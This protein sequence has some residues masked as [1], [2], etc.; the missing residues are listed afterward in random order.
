M[1]DYQLSKT[2]MRQT[3]GLIAGSFK[4]LTRGHFFLIQRA[5]EECDR[6]IV[7]VSTGD[8]Q[9]S[10]EVP[11][12]WTQMEL[13]W[14]KFLLKAMPSNVS[15]KFVSHPIRGVIDILR[16]ANQ[17]EN[18]FNTYIIYSDPEDMANNYNSRTQVKY[19]PR[20]LKNEQVIFKP[21]ERK[22]GINISGTQMR[23]YLGTGNV[24]AF[25]RGLPKSV[26]GFGNEIFQILGGIT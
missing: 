26:Q 15:I 1:E 5:S 16:E 13:V 21:F 14:Q 25:I 20:L 7:F 24:K 11:I 19:F 6:V 8:R 18:N 10:G 4:P 3:I 9:R 17:N 22:A 2:H 23:N 12:T